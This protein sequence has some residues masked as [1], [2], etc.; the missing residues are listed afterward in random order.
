MTNGDVRPSNSFRIL[1]IN[2]N[3]IAVVIAAILTIGGVKLTQYL[4]SKYYFSFSQL[5]SPDTTSPF[6]IATPAYVTADKLCD[7]VKRDKR[8]TGLTCNNEGQQPNQKQIEILNQDIKDQVHAGNST[9]TLIGLAIRLCIPLLAGFL[10]GRLFGAEAQLAAPIG[11][12]A[13][14]LLLCWPVIVLWDLV[15]ASSFKRQY[16]S[17]LLLYILYCILFYYTARLGATLG[18][19]TSLISPLSA[20]KID[21]TKFI[22]TILGV[23]ATG[24]GTQLVQ[25]VILQQ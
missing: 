17:F 24:I 13:G 25:H 1:T 2:V 22:E 18:T 15:V 14:A 20:R 8:L 11:A 19:Q 21:V 23:V 16:G 3:L 10:V 5:V 4:P 7:M 12:A 9:T 6:L